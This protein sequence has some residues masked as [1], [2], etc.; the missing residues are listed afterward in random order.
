MQVKR[1]HKDESEENAVDD[2]TDEEMEEDHSVPLVTHVNKLCIQFFLL[3]RCKST[4]S[5]PTTLMDCMRTSLTL[6]KTSSEPVLST[7]KFCTAKGMTIKYLLM[8]LWN[9]PSPKRFSLTE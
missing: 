7:R 6:P 8:K 4:I 2:T 3:L 9:L 5:K 1:E